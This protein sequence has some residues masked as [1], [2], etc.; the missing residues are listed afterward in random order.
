MLS[1]NPYRISRNKA[2][3]FPYIPILFQLW[4]VYNPIILPE[5][6]NCGKPNSKATLFGGSY[7][8]S[9]VILGMI[10]NYCYPI[11][12]NYILSH[13]YP[14]IQAKPNGSGKK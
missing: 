2:N 6:P 10:Y 9:M 7:H 11:I 3:M 5:F 8:P 13:Y 12:I 1:Q 14:I 4:L